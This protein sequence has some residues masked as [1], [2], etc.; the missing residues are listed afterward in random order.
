MVATAV[1]EVTLEGKQLKLSN[2]SKLIWPEGL[3]KA[4]LIKYYTDIAPFLLPH[5]KGRPLVMK[6]YP[7]GVSGEYFYHKECPDY[8]PE[9]MQTV[10]IRHSKKRVN[11]IVC[12]DTATLVWLANQGCIEMHAWLSRHPRVEYPDLAVIDLDPGRQAAFQD[13]LAVAEVVR[14]VLDYL[15]LLGFPKTSGAA[16]IHIFIPIRPVYTFREVTGAM[17]WLAGLV[18]RAVPDK[19]TVTRALAAREPH[20]VY[21]DYLQNTRGKSM[22][23]TYSLRPL[24]GAPVSTPVLWEE[25]EAGCI[26]PSD[27]TLNTV[28]CRLKELGDLHHD[29]FKQAQDL[30]QILS[31]TANS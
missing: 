4:H 31:L 27:F 18:T 9:W 30:S 6:R 2:L 24:P 14:Q 16:G 7:H 13:V 1:T 23:W 15:G 19:A 12:H 21:V 10:S 22:A 3:T 25:I 8:A 11:Y 20:K 17:E 28:F 29:M 26:M 5:I